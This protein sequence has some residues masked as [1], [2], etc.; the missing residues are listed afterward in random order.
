MLALGIRYLNG[1]AM[2]AADGAR[3]ELAEW[4]PHPDRV[5]MA[6]AAAW[7]ETGEDQEEGDALRWLETLDPP[8][9]SASDADFRRALRENRPTVSYVP[10]NDSQRGRKLPDTEDVR[11]LKDAGLALL[12]EHRL[13][14]ARTFP[15]A[16]P[17]HP[18][19]FLLWADTDP[20]QHRDAL[21]RLVGKVSHVGHSASFVQMWLEDSPP[22]PTWIAVEGQA[23]HRLRVFGPGR[24][25]YLNAR[26]NRGN[27]IAYADLHAEIKEAKGKVKKTLQARAQERFGDRA[28]VS[29]RPEPGRWQGYDR[30]AKATTRTT[31]GSLFD[32]RLT[33]LA[34]FGRRLSLPA[35]LKLTE[36]LRGA[37]LSACPEPAPEWVSGHQPDGRPSSDP[38]LALL[39]LPFVGHE[40]ADGRLMGVALALPKR[41]DPA[42]TTYYLGPL[43][44]D[45][46]GLPHRSRLF[47][48]H[49]LECSAELEV[50]ES[51]PTSLRSEVWTG[52]SRTW[53]SVSPVV[54]DRHFD[55]KDKWERA[56]ET[57]KDACERIGL[58]RP[59][60]VLMH[61][62]SLVEGVPH[63]RDFPRI[64]RKRDGGRMHHSHA[65]I[66]F[67]EAVEGPVMV[68]A[69]RFRGYGLCWPMD[70]DAGHD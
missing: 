23:A 45:K 47:A 60:E 9:I 1:W 57:V 6:L 30:P 46:H 3:K 37:V 20:K 5:F 68:G 17:R 28:P 40:H 4:P 29:L 15:V 2:A 70:K 63:A 34:L 61:P 25:H 54:L 19:I 16:V 12:P 42:Q 43:L 14:Q 21:N 48:G 33:V 49:W 32:P 59:R 26:C 8:A 11:K 22:E 36:T 13:R 50:R 67:D 56:A 35:T 31:P 44:R 38:H 18:V 65:V 10:V 66:L 7:F 51:P 41:I 55:G 58:P 27:V 69:G 62:V 39:P 52:P 53:A 64:T 24:L